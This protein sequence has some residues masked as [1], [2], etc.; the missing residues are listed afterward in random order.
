VRVVA[1][2]GVNWPASRSARRWAFSSQASF[3]RTVFYT[4]T[5]AP[6]YPLL[7]DSCFFTLNGTI[8]NAVIFRGSF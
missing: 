5:L 6:Q 1:A 3:S 8:S 2:W 4:S 7:V